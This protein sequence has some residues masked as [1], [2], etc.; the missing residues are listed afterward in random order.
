[1][2]AL[3]TLN[4]KGALQELTQRIGA[5]VP[6]YQVVDISGPDHDPQYSVEISILNNPLA[7]ASAGSRKQAENK[8]AEIVLNLL[9]SGDSSLPA[10]LKEKMELA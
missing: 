6:R 3:D 5:K 8:A 7:K 9:K 1:M 10:V 2:E 4:P